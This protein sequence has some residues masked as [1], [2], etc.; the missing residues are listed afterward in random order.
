MAQRRRHFCRL[1]RSWSAV[2]QAPQLPAGVGAIGMDMG[3]PEHARGASRA[4]LFLLKGVLFRNHIC[5]A[6]STTLD[7]RIHDGWSDGRT[8][9]QTGRRADG[10]MDGRTDGWTH[11]WIDGRIDEQTD[12][13][14][15]G[16]AGVEAPIE[17]AWYPIR[18]TISGVEWVWTMNACGGDGGHHHQ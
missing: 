5:V 13:V 1:G 3:V 12:G 17:A 10:W 15:G 14:A 11:G 7:E 6:L 18:I 16:S 9:G 4:P 2:A 8:H